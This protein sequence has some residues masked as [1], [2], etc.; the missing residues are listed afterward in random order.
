MYYFF[1]GARGLVFASVSHSTVL[2]S[3][4]ICVFVDPCLRNGVREAWA[5]RKR[6][7]GTLPQF[8][9]RP[10]P[11]LKGPLTTQVE[12]DPTV[13]SGV[14]DFMQFLDDGPNDGKV[15]L[16]TLAQ[17]DSLRTPPSKWAFWSS[18]KPGPSQ[19][20][21]VISPKA[22]TPG[23]SHEFAGVPLGALP[24]GLTD[25]ANDVVQADILLQARAVDAMERILAHPASGDTSPIPFAER[26]KTL[27]KLQRRV[28]R[29]PGSG[30]TSATASGAPSHAPTRPSSPTAVGE[31]GRPQKH[32]HRGR[33]PSITAFQ[34]RR[35]SITINHNQ[36][37]PR[38]ELGRRDR[39]QELAQKLYEELQSQL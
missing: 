10:F 11:S 39:A 15:D 35:A 5:A 21:P 2:H 32:S 12:S 24:S 20:S 17:A 31:V 26:L 16:P 37:T 9:S 25:D 8:E 18:R 22:E 4:Q 34:P 27:D 33:R 29:G 3:P 1:Y 38:Q 6:D 36:P 7:K 28:D 23:F 30:R 14:M 13:T 19:P